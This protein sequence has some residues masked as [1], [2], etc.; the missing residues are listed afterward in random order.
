MS[1]TY[2]TLV[3]L[4]LDYAEAESSE[5]VE[6][7]QIMVELAE[8]RLYRDLDTY[9]FVFHA[10]TSV[11]SGDPLITKP[12][13]SAIV[14]AL[15]WVSANQQKV[16]ELKTDEFVKLYWPQRNSVGTS[17]P[18]YWANWDATTI[19][20]CP[21]VGNGTLEMS[22]VAKPAA[23]TSANT[24]NW[25]TSNAER[26]LIAGTMVEA[27]LFMKNKDQSEM[28]DKRYMEELQKLL[29]ESRRSRVDD[30]AA[31]TNPNGENNITQGAS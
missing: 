6:R 8:D 28:W 14:K 10:T 31:N 3:S 5:F 2:I 22:Y 26:A 15:S 21:T 1:I 24:T 17:P 12:T 29:N 20:L 13:G 30:Q 25:F 23:L 19:I 16:L 11:S 9:G 18:K 7:I 27:N 4:I